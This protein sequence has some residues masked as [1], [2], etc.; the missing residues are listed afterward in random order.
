MIVG[1]QFFFI[2][3]YPAFGQAKLKWMFKNK[4]EK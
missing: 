3:N 4:T 1:E 2:K